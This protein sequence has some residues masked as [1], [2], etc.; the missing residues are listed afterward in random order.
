[1]REVLID[2]R[3]SGV[4]RIVTARPGA[5]LGFTEEADQVSDVSDRIG[6]P[7]EIEI[8]ESDLLAIDQ[9]VVRFEV[10]MDQGRRSTLQT[11]GYRLHHPGHYVD[12][13]GPSRYKKRLRFLEPGNL[14]RGGTLRSRD[15]EPVKF[16]DSPRRRSHRIN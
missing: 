14:I 10:T 11:Y 5:L 8:D 4:F 7:E 16:G 6:A 15:I 3:P 2:E 13:I 12:Q 9:D 1:M